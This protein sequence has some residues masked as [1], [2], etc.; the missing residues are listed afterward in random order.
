[1][2]FDDNIQLSD[3]HQ[4]EAPGANVG[5]SE[6]PSRQYMPLV[7]DQVQKNNSMKNLQED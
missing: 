3:R 2:I 7:Q 5:A 1:M 4:E 6:P